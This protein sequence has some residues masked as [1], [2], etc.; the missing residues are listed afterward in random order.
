MDPVEQELAK[1]LNILKNGE[2]CEYG[3]EDE[4]TKTT[5]EICKSG[6]KFNIFSISIVEDKKEK[7]ELEKGLTAKKVIEYFHLK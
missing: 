6:V 7:L 4:N 1:K 3:F 2:C 5:Y